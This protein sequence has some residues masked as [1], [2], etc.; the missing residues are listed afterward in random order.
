MESFRGSEFDT[1][2]QQYGLHL[3]KHTTH[4]NSVLG[5]SIIFLVCLKVSRFSSW[6]SQASIFTSNVHV[7][8]AAQQI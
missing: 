4:K 1:V 6:V 3:K 2:H 5:E 7:N 8:T